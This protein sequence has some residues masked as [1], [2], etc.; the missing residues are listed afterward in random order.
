[1][2]WEIFP[3][4]NADSGVMPAYRK[5]IWNSSLLSVMKQDSDSD[6]KPESKSV[7]DPVK[8]D[9]GIDA[10]KVLQLVGGII[11]AIFVIWMIFHS[12]LHII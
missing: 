8:E 3:R 9:T 2:F 11:C 1:M 5:E 10:F 12:I 4:M 6:K 7:G